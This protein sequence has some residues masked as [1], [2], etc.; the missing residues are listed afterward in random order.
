MDRSA[1]RTD[2]DICHRRYPLRPDGINDI[3]CCC[4]PMA[5]NLVQGCVESANNSII[6]FYS[7]NIAFR[8]YIPQK[9]FSVVDPT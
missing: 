4:P 3:M 9:K 7:K 5:Y 2:R 8:F 6:F 1:I